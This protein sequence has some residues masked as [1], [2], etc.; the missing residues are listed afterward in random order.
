M[1]STAVSIIIAGLL[2]GGAILLSKSS[3]DSGTQP[4]NAQNV[5]VANGKQVVEISAR[6][7]YSPRRSVAKAGIPTVLKID[8]NNTFD[9]SSAIR[10]PSMHVSRNLPSS[11]STEIDLGNPVT[12]ALRGTCGMGMYSFEIDFE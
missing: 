9:C 4:A 6:G 7:G 11:G 8:T 5:S 12:G 2:I 10:I 3:T 1:R